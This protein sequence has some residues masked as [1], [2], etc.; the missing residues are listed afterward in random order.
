MTDASFRDATPVRRTGIGS[1]A[2]QWVTALVGFVIIDR[3]RI[4]VQ[5]DIPTG[6]PTNI[7]PKWIGLTFAPALST[8]LLWIYS[9]MPDAPG[10]RRV[11]R[12][13]AFTILALAELAIV[14]LNR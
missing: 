2:I 10:L 6:D 5:W 1:V 11:L 4:A 8:V 7:W 3:A 9:R 13:G 12:I 14:I